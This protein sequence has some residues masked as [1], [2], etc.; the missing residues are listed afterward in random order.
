[1]GTIAVAPAAESVHSCQRDLTP[2]KSSMKVWG[3]ELFPLQ[4]VFPPHLAPFLQSPT[5]HM[6]HSTGGLAHPSSPALLPL[7]PAGKAVQALILV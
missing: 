4:V 5:R 3:T 6:W 2:P 7:D 1:M